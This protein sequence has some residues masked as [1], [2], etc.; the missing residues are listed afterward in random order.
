MLM[1]EAEE[2]DQNGDYV[3]SNSWELT[4]DI[5]SKEDDEFLVGYLD[6]PRFV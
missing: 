5:A 1:Q 6:V 3:W 4:P 2:Q